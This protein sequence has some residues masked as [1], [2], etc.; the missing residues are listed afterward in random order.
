MKIAILLFLTLCTISLI[1]QDEVFDQDEPQYK[2]EQELMNFIKS[3][4]DLYRHYKSGQRNLSVG[5]GFGYT[6]IGFLGGGVALIAVG[7]N[8]GSWDG[9][10]YVIL[11]ALSIVTG[12]VL[13]TIG[14]IFHVNGKD[15]IRDVMD[16]AE[17]EVG[18]SY[19]V[20]LK[21]KI[22]DNGLGFVYSF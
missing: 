3:D 7:S 4:V 2:R 6:S 14:V 1:A 18:G 13:G 15:K 20:E 8:V 16:Y 5:K 19:G 12:S 22:T 11:G 9:L 21:L 17:N 10:G